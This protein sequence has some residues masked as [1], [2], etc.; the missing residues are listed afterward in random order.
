MTRLIGARC[1]HSNVFS[2]GVLMHQ[3]FL[4]RNFEERNFNLK[5]YKKSCI[6]I[7]NG[8][9][10]EQ[11]IRL[12][13]EGSSVQIRPPVPN[14]RRGFRLRKNPFVTDDTSKESIQLCF[15]KR[16]K[17]KDKNDLID[18]PDHLKRG[19]FTFKGENSS[20]F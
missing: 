3:E 18:F 14:L 5:K 9:S 17:R 11:S 19:I 1:K 2:R 10:S 4:S 8:G 20:N 6:H 15:P 7:V 16:K 12:L 13:V